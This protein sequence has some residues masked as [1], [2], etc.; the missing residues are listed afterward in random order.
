M[1]GRPKGLNALFDTVKKDNKAN[2]SF[3]KTWLVERKPKLYP[4][5]II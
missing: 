3:I 2:K 4:P 5:Q 1:E